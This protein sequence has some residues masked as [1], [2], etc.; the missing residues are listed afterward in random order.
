MFSQVTVETFFP[1]HLE[2]LV[3]TALLSTITLPGFISRTR[4]G[5]EGKNGEGKR[6]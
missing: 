6:D 1:V 5:V 2:T 4:R 3:S